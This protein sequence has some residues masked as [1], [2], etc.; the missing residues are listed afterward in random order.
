MSSRT[1]ASS[2][3]NS[4]RWA[5]PWSVRR[6]S[7]SQLR[8]TSVAISQVRNDAATARMANTSQVKRSVSAPRRSA[9]L[10][11]CTSVTKPTGSFL[12]SMI[13]IA[14]TCTL[15][16]ASVLTSFQVCQA[17]AFDVEAA[18]TRGPSTS[19]AKL[20][21]KSSVRATMTRSGLQAAAER[22]RSSRVI[23]VR[24]RRMRSASPSRQ[25]R[26]RPQRAPLTASWAR[27]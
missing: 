4:G 25:A 6:A 21:G 8:Q 18:R 23:S 2:G 27:S 20:P 7:P 9:K 24:T 19:Q 26:M 3:W 14:L 13:G 15:P 17:S 12:S 16:L 10:M 11:S 22:M 5:P 1:S